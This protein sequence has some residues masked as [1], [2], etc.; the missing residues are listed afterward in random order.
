MQNHVTYLIVHIQHRHLNLYSSIDDTK[1]HYS[2]AHLTRR[3]TKLAQ[4]SFKNHAKMG[5]SACLGRD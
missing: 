4:K 3:S 1:Y 2:K 5:P